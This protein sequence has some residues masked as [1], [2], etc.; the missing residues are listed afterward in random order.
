MTSDTL[1]FPEI[2]KENLLDSN[3][4]YVSYNVDLLFT[5]IYLGETLDSILDEIYIWKKLEPLCKKSVFKKLLNKLCKSCT[6][7]ADG[8]LIRQVGGCPMGGP[9][10]VDLSNI[11]C[12]KI[13]F[14]V[15]KP[16][17]PKLFKCY[18]NDSKWTK[19]QPDTFFEKLNNYH[20]N[21]KLAIEV[22]P[23]KFLDIEIMI[24]DG[25]TETSAAVK[26]SKMSNHWSSA[27]PKS[28]N[29]MWF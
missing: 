28:I 22:N 2:F 12:V 3:E 5:S 1:S 11:F 9:I 26:E 15:I 10:S 25:I 17:K 18:V 14:D 24:K 29:E 8:K 4:E 6:F 19:N 20:P 13:D 16:L 21:I 23:S 7:L 27:V